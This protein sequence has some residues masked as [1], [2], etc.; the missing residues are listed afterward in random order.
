MKKILEQQKRRVSETAKIYEGDSQLR[1]GFALEEQRQLESDQRHWVKRLAAIDR[2]LAEEPRRI[3][4]DL[5]REGAADRADRAGL[6][7]AGDWITNTHVIQRLRPSQKQRMAR[8]PPADGPRRVA[9]GTRRGPCVPER[10]H[11]PRAQSL[12]GMCR[13]KSRYAGKDEKVPAIT[14]FPRFCSH[15]LGWRPSDLVGSKEGGPLPETLESVL[16][17]YHETLRPTYAV[18]HPESKPEGQSPWMLLVKVLPN[19][20]ALRRLRRVR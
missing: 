20:T 7:L 14:D 15:V 18:K 1:M 2:E 11:H 10:E 4:R 3:R 13:T 8:L 16:T 6:S 5:R 12:P 9:S 17:D 19:G